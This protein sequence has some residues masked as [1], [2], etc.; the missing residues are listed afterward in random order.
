MIFNNNEIMDYRKVLEI[1]ADSAL[2]KET[3]EIYYP[4][5]ESSPEGWREIEPYGIST[6][7]DNQGEVLNYG[8]D[9]I[10]PGHI[11]KAYTLNSGLTECHS[12]ILGKIKKARKTKRK[13]TPR[14][15]WEFNF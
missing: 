10:S 2:K 8:R 4:A 3:V 13:F 9:S 6:D 1:I 7:I 15:D 5:T 14:K 12:F 11:L